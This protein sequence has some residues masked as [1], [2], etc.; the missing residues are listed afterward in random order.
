MQAGN[1]VA[2]VGSY[3]AALRFAPNHHAARNNRAAAHL[4]LGAWAAAAADATAVLAAEPTN[5]KALFRRAE[6]QV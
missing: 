5:L 6:A 1:F 2:A 3:T 4:R